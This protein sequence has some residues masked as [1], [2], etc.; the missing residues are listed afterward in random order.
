MDHY[1]KGEGGDPPPHEVDYPQMAEDEE[2][3]A[4]EQQ[5]SP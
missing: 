1:L 4:E 2:E 3:E 5:A